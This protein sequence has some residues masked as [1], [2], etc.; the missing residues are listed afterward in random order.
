MAA[1]GTWA[2]TVEGGFR[3]VCERR[4]GTVF[5]V[6]RLAAGA[7]ARCERGRLPHRPLE[8]QARVGVRFDELEGRVVRAVLC[9]DA[10]VVIPGGPRRRTRRVRGLVRGDAHDASVRRA[11]RQS[12]P[13]RQQPRV[14]ARQ[15]YRPDSG[16]GAV[17]R[18]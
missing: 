13:S 12:G 6:S 4:F 11:H 1:Y 15:P 18:P 10:A 14:P 2:G 8:G 16:S 7:Q 5:R 17:V 3:R 9:G